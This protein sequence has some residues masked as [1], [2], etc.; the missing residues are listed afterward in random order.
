MKIGE[1][2]ERDGVRRTVDEVYYV[3]EGQN[4]SHW[5]RYTTKIGPNN[6][7]S[8]STWDKWVKDATLLTNDGDD[9]GN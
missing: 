1:T 6:Y 7:E 2:Y 8:K 4:A 9:D 3:G 5:V